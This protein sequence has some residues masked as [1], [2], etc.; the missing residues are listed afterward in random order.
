VTLLRPTASLL[1]EGAGA[2]SLAGTGLSAAQAAVRRLVVE[3]SVDEAHD[4]VELAV[5]RDSALS[6]A[7]PGAEL[8]IGLGVTDD[9]ADVLTVEIAG[10]DATG[11]GTLVTGYAPSRRLSATYVGRSYVDRTVG[12]VVADLLAE[13][14]VAEGDVDA[15]LSLPVLHV[16]PRRSV[17]GNLHALARTCGCQVTTKEDGSVSFTPIP[18]AVAGGLGGGLSAVAGAVGL[19]ST[20]ELREGVELLAFRVGGRNP[21]PTVSLVTPLGAKAG[22]L[23]AEPDPGSGPPVQV[24]PVLRTQE[25]ADA[26]T[27]A[28]E[29]A[30]RRRGRTASLSVPGRADLRAGGTVRARGQD[31]RVLRVRHVLDADS[32]YRCDL[33]LEGD[34]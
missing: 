4:R 21:E 28:R 25:A 31:Y 18:G 9:V 12:D 19:G 17:W 13:G 14:Q 5:W 3:L 22:L 32:G 11:W 33:L 26:A 6:S 34:R 8:V 27:T 29:A 15:S 30:A 20:G 10:A 7:A 16:D 1:L 24:D 2:S 23:V